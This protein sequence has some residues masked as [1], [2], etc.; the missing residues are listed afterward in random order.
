MTI[1]LLLFISYTHTKNIYVTLMKDLVQCKDWVLEDGI[2]TSRM[3]PKTRDSS[4]E[5]H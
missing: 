1:I 5:E 2:L 4:L 3:C